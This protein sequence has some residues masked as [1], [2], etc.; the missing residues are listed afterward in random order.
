MRIRESVPPAVANEIRLLD[1]DILE[2]GDD[3]PFGDGFRETIA[4]C[5][6]VL[7][8]IGEGS[9]G[10]T[11]W[12][13]ERRMLSDQRMVDLAHSFIDDGSVED[14]D[15]EWLGEVTDDLILDLAHAVDAVAMTPQYIANALKHRADLSEDI[16]HGGKWVAYGDVVKPSGLNE[17][18][19]CTWDVPDG[20]SEMETLEQ[21]IAATD[22]NA[23]EVTAFSLVGMTETEF[24]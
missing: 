16:G 24:T 23:V 10:L 19:C 21:V 1:I 12:A 11:M 13:R 9:K 18:Y 6:N 2:R 3:Y 15:T 4:Y 14:K 20:H 7:A 17:G 5:S 22:W 8:D